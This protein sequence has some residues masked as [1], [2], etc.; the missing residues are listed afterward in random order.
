[1]FIRT[2]GWGGGM[3]QGNTLSSYSALLSI[4]C[5]KTSWAWKQI[6]KK[7]NREMFFIFLIF[8]SVNKME[9]SRIYITV[10]Q[11]EYTV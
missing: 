9:L 3:S 6:C 1:M 11:Q 5:I 2:G 4:V 10:K 7:Q 8:H